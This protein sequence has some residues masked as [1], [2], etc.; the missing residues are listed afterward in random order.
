MKKYFFIISILFCS[1]NSYSQ[2]TLFGE[3][4]ITP[5][6][7]EVGAVN[8]SGYNLVFNYLRMP[9]NKISDNQF[10][11]E[12]DSAFYEVVK[13]NINNFSK[14]NYVVRSLTDTFSYCSTHTTIFNKFNNRYY[15]NFCI[16]KRSEIIDPNIL[17]IIDYYVESYDTNMTNRIVVKLE[18]MPKISRSYAQANKLLEK[19]LFIYSI[20]IDSFNEFPK[21][22]KLNL[23]NGNII[24][25]CN[26]IDKFSGLPPP[27]KHS[28]F[29]RMDWLNDSVIIIFSDI[30]QYVNVKTMTLFD[31]TN[32]YFPS[33]NDAPNGAI[34]TIKF[35]PVDTS[36]IFCGT[37]QNNYRYYRIHSDGKCL[38]K[39]EIPLSN[40]SPFSYTS[41]AKTFNNF[42]FNF[43]NHIYT[44]AVLFPPNSDTFAICHSNINGITNWIKIL[45]SPGTNTSTNMIALEDSTLFAFIN[46][47][48]PNDNEKSDIYYLRLNQYGNQVFPLGVESKFKEINNVIVY[49]NPSRGQF[50]IG[51]LHLE[52]INSINIYNT[53]G[54]LIK[55]IKPTLIL[56]LNDFPAQNYIVEIN[57]QTEKIIKSILIK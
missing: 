34:L 26:L 10:Y 40:Y 6:F 51:N 32:L 27:F 37:V 21:I 45:K 17:K 2:N 23:L 31:S 15:F 25:T 57:T 30:I 9:Y 16:E 52:D 5:Y 55:Q 33:I 13:Y 39:F 20:S 22:C 50:F 49:P 47:A 18:K 7:E 46:V 56:N 3:Y 12:A 42:D 53:S 44:S 4:A 1:T 36:Y 48:Q 24:D 28:G 38:Y 35:N 19:D 54:Q 14:K 29:I 11:E 41:I 8:N 43:S